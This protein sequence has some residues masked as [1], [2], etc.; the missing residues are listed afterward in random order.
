MILAYVM[1]VVCAFSI[2]SAAMSIDKVVAVK[3]FETSNTI[4]VAALTEP[5]FSR[6]EN[7]ELKEKISIAVRETGFTKRIIVS[8]DLD[9]Y[10]KIKDDMSAEQKTKLIETL[11]SRS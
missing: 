9:I 10:S 8:F 2:E 1:A 7:N 11:D 6:T 3:C 5:I 4:V